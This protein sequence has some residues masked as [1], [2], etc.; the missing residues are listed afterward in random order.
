[1]VAGKRYRPVR[2]LEGFRGR[3]QRGW[4]VPE[5]LGVAEYGE[6]RPSPMQVNSEQSVGYDKVRLA[7]M[8]SSSATVTAS[9][10]KASVIK[11]DFGLESSILRSPSNTLTAPTRLLSA[12]IDAGVL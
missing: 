5:I 6:L 4:V 11:T 2:K 12:G 3:G 8:V 10:W 7:V 1:V 9:E